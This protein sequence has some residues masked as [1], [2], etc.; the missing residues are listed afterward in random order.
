MPKQLI[1]N[2]YEKA[3]PQTLRLL[4]ERN[5]CQSETA[6]CDDDD[7]YSGRDGLL[8]RASAGPN[9][10]LLSM[11]VGLNETLVSMDVR[12]NETLLS[13]DVGVNGRCSWRT[14]IRKVF[15]SVDKQHHDL[16]AQGGGGTAGERGGRRE[17]GMEEDTRRKGCTGEQEWTV[18]EVRRR[19]E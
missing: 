18:I 3:S 13:I 8:S 19:L 14:G 7:A 5:P 6:S 2:G 12:L 11:D 9:Q 16:A 10:T 17:R 4:R 15:L 1:H